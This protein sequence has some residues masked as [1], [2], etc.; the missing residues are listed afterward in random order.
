MSVRLVTHNSLTDFRNWLEK[1]FPTD[2]SATKS[3]DFNVRGNYSWGNNG[4]FFS[5][6]GIQQT[7]G[8]KGNN[9]YGTRDANSVFD[10][11]TEYLD[12]PLMESVFNRISNQIDISSTNKLEKRKMTFNDM[13]IGLFSFDRASQTMSYVFEYYSPSLGMLVGEENVI[14][15]GD[16]KYISKL[17]GKPLIKRHKMNER[18][19]AKKKAGYRFYSPVFEEYIDYVPKVK[20]ATKKVFV[21]F[22][23]SVQM[24]DNGFKIVIVSGGNSDKSASQLLH[25]SMAG[26]KLAQALDLAGYPVQISAMYA[27]RHNNTGDII[28]TEVIIKR[29][30]EIFDLNLIS[31]MG[32]D[33]RIFRHEGFKALIAASDDFGVTIPSG[34]GSMDD[35][36]IQPIEDELNSGNSVKNTFVFGLTYDIPSIIRSYN[37]KT[38]EIRQTMNQAQTTTP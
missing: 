25:S 14:K 22:P 1:R 13:G 20:T 27:C 32:S 5:V 30:D 28:G 12:K 19:T 26:M 11:P 15:I 9:W 33:P 34:L 31:L 35:S 37:E 4:N 36:I 7:I 29:F 17:D 38:E 10:K 16:N 18:A 6:N 2:G 8:S 3:S 24:D 21:Y 23:K